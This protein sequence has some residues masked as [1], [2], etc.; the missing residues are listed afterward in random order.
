MRRTMAGRAT[1]AAGMMPPSGFP[2]S[3]IQSTVPLT[4][5]AMVSE[6]RTSV[7]K[8]LAEE[9]SS[10]ARDA[11][12]SWLRSRTAALPPLRHISTTQALPRPDA[13]RSLV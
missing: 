2:V 9:P 6:S 10:S 12:R 13:L 3:R 5:A 8:N 4:A 7:R 11:P 1:P